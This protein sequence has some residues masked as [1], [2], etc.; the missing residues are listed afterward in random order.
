MVAEKGQA[1][2]MYVQRSVCGVYGAVTAQ[3]QGVALVPQSPTG[4]HSWPI[5]A[6]GEF[7]EF[8][9]DARRPPASARM[10]IYS[11]FRR[12]CWVSETLKVLIR[13]TT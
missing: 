11:T 8:G 12:H 3:M 13:H 9:Q 2:A 10:F 5:S 4:L 1:Q 7:G 6:R